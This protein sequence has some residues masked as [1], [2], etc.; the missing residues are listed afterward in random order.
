VARGSDGVTRKWKGGGERAW[1]VVMFLQAN[2]CLIVS[3]IRFT[4]SL[5]VLTCLI[6]WRV[7]SMEGL[8][9]GI[10]IGGGN[11]MIAT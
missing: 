5:I 10:S 11:L 9:W 8:I 6:N 7:I 2:G 4:M 3:H 1:K